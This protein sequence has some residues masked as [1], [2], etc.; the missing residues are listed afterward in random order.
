MA[1][2]KPWRRR[3]PKTGRFV[4]KQLLAD[5]KKARAELDTLGFTKPKKYRALK[6]TKNDKLW[7]NWKVPPPSYQY[8]SHGIH[9]YGWNFR[10][11]EGHRRASTALRV[12]ASKYSQKVSRVY[13]GTGKGHFA[14][15]AS[16]KL[17]S[18]VAQHQQI[19]GM[20][21]TKS[22]EKIFRFAQE[23]EQIYFIVEL[24]SRTKLR[25]SKARNV[26]LVKP[27]QRNNR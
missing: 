5:R 10:G 18:P 27:K 26:P 15:W 24:F 4:S 23:G 12:L 20:I 16:T 1:K 2:R 13:I 8:D 9:V 11:L 17:A 14:D 25:F 22:G 7:D 19:S 3:D 6:P 21:K